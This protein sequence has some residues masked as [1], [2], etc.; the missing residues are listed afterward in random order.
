MNAPFGL[1]GKVQTLLAGAPTVLDGQ[2]LDPQMQIIGRFLKAVGK[3]PNTR[4]HPAVRGEFNAMSLAMD[5]ADPPMSRNVELS[6]P[7]PGGAI[8][9]TLH[10]P[11]DL[12]RSAP[13]VVYFHG[14]GFVVGS[15]ETHAGLCHRI[16]AGAKA[17]VVNVEYRLAPEAPFPAAVEDCLAAYRWAVENG[18]AHGIDPSRIAVAGDS[19]GGCLAAVVSI[20]ARDGGLAL[21]KAQ[22]LIY[23]ITDSAAQTESRRIF[24]EGFL[25]EG[26]TIAWFQKNYLQKNEVAD[27]RASPLVTP[28]LAGLPPAFVSTAGFDPLRDE[29]E[30]YAAKLTDAGVRTTVRRYPGLIHGFANLRFS[31]PSRDAI[32]EGIAWLHREL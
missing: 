20:L 25:L 5:R 17:I 29:G 32:D 2:T 19:A 6:V 1:P 11:F 14:G 3:D 16:A 31:K 28:S 22:W 15:R 10:V 18:A 23:P 12:P 13:A 21:P 9:V 30:A 26:R 24:A 8:P 4:P 27:F 7:G